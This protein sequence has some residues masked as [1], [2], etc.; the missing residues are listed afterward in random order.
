MLTKSL[1][2]Y[3]DLMDT[4][5]TFCYCLGLCKLGFSENIL[6]VSGKSVSEWLLLI[7]SCPEGWEHIAQCLQENNAMHN[8]EPSVVTRIKQIS[9]GWE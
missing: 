1:Q 4:K 8:W 7:L 6:K 9:G 2:Q 3:E 5:N